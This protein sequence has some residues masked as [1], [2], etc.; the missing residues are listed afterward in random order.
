MINSLY[1][2]QWSRFQNHFCP[3]LKLLEKKRI[4]NKYDRNYE[5]PKTPYQRLIESQ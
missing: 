2:N 5:N 3:T 4:N 1:T